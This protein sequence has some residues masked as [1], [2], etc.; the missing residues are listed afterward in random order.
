MEN[1]YRVT[2]V[3]SPGDRFKLIFECFADDE[4]HA[5]EQAMDAY[6]G[7]TVLHIT[8]ILED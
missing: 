5:E 6:P 4:D 8:K 2:L 1:N 3:E 7:C